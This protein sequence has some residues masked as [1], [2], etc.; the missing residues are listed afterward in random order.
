MRKEPLYKSTLGSLFI[1]LFLGWGGFHVWA[2]Q[3]GP[4]KVYYESGQVQEEGS[5]KD[6]KK[7]GPFKAY[8]E[9]G[10]LQ[11]E[12]VYKD[13]NLDGPFKAYYKRETANGMLTRIIS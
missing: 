3:T 12:G 6:G 5:Y 10:Q 7:D 1:V 2:N 4:Y 11:E 13:D 8:Y 9:S